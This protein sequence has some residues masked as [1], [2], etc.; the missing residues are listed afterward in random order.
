MKVLSIYEADDARN[1]GKYHRADEDVRAVQRDRGIPLR[2]RANADA[3]EAL[4]VL[5]MKIT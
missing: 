2:N 4:A 5:G 3:K 1:K